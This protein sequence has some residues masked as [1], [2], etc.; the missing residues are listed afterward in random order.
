MIVL[1]VGCRR[2]GTTIFWKQFRQDPR[3]VCYDEPFNP[4]IVK[5]VPNDNPKRTL[6]ELIELHARNPKLFWQRYTPITPSEEALPTLSLAQAD[7]LRFLSKTGRIVVI[8]TTRCHLKLRQIVE[9]H[10]D[11]VLIHLHRAPAAFASSHL[12][13]SGQGRE[14]DYDEFWEKTSGFNKWNIEE[15]IGMDCRGPLGHRILKM[16]G[17]DPKRPASLP[18]ILKLLTYWKLHFDE[19]EQTG[20]GIFG[21]RF[22]SVRFEDFCCGPEKVLNAVYRLL[23]LQ[24][25]AVDLSTVHAPKPAYFVDDPKWYRY[26]S[27]AGL[28]PERSSL[29]RIARGV[30]GSSRGYRAAGTGA[31]LK[32]AARK[33]DQNLMCGTLVGLYHRIMRRR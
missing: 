27:M 1:I 7:Y 26:A 8:D 2:S 4:L 15:I 31:K 5:E 9:T 21:E 30:N 6:K 14:P 18:A 17:H 24:S 10:P 16:L 3:F 32:Y 11:S 25:P 22:L 23:D 29:F 19:V 20:A 28:P 33:L 12:L 13:P